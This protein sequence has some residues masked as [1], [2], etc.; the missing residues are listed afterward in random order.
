MFFVFPGWVSL[1]AIFGIGKAIILVS[2]E[3]PTAG[4]S[5][6]DLQSSLDDI[7]GTHKATIHNRHT[8]DP[9]N[10]VVFSTCT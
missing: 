6:Q 7:I 10:H 4:I 3:A 2:T 8:R 5:L 9:T 1:I